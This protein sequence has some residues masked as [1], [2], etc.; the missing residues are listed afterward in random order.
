[1]LHNHKDK[2]S[3]PIDNLSPEMQTSWELLMKE[4]FPE[5]TS[6]QQQLLAGQLVPPAPAAQDSAGAAANRDAGGVL[7]RQDVLELPHLNVA[8][9]R[10]DSSRSTSKGNV[11]GSPSDFQV[12]RARRCH[13]G[14]HSARLQFQASSPNLTPPSRLSTSTGGDDLSA[15]ALGATGS[16]PCLDCGELV[17]G[18]DALAHVYARHL[19][20]LPL[21]VCSQCGFDDNDRDKLRR[22]LA[23]EHRVEPEAQVSIVLGGFE[24]IPN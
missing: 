11:E 6:Q 8:Y 18:K 19:A 17:A 13:S 12:Q 7:R 23:S 4:C 2:D 21:F 24:V 15:R 1:M 16:L 5:H 20:F 22:H 14:C 3:Q 9:E 10:P